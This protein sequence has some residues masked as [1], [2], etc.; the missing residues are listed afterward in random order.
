MYTIQSN[1]IFKILKIRKGISF[2]EDH[3]GIKRLVCFNKP[4]PLKKECVCG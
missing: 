1:V 2:L 4:N 3:Q